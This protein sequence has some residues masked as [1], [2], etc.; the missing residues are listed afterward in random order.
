MRCRLAAWGGGKAGLCPPVG[1]VLMLVVALSFAGCSEE[2]SSTTSEAPVTAATTAPAGT[3]TLSTTPAAPGLTLE[4]VR[5]ATCRLEFEGE[6]LTFTLVDGSYQIG[7]GQA[8]GLGQSTGQGAGQGKGVGQGQGAGQGAGVSPQADRLK[9]TMM[10]P[11]A[12][13]DLNGDGVGDAAIVLRVVKGKGGDGD[14]QAGEPGKSV[15]AGNKG[16]SQYV[17]ALV[18]EGGEPAQGG[19]RLVGVGTRID[20]LEI[21]DAEIVADATVPGQEEPSG[22]PKMPIRVALTLPFDGGGILLHTFQSS[23]TPVGGIRE[24]TIT[25]P[26][27]GATV[28]SPFTITGSITIAPFE[29]NLV[30]QLYDLQMT[31]RAIGPVTVEAADLGAPGTFSFT[32]DLSSARITGPIF[33]TISDLSAVD[34]SILAMASIRLAAE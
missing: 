4:Q 6:L 31:E 1:A 7:E 5:N 3:T 20:A 21:V 17:V 19:Y 14:D 24:I 9:V 15:G 10:D 16:A 30:Y 25:S 33:V 2:Q 11:V 12:F 34:G 22:D 23:E 29:N 32:L 8:T 27:P 18:S 28:R 26:A 13:G